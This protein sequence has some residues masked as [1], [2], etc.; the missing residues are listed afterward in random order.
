MKLLEIVVNPAAL[1]MQYIKHINHNNLSSKMFGAGFDEICHEIGNCSMVSNHFSDWLNDKDISNRIV[2]G[3]HAKD[4]RWPKNA[5][6]T[7]GSDEDAH[8]VVLIGNIIVDF[9]A[10]QFDKSLPFPRVIPFS[11][12][13]TEW[14]SIK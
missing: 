11:R 4:I 2:V 8:T 14:T 6:V 10:R 3:I 13:K 7:P 1:A 9:T 5:H 12:F